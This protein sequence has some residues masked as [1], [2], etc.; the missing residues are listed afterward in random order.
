MNKKDFLNQR[1]SGGVKIENPI[2]K[3]PGRPSKSDSE[4][5]TEKVTVTLTP[6]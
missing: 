2:F 4:K 1:K 3:K 6:K 5:L